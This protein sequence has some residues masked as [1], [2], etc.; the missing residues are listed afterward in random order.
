[1]LYYVVMT[2]ESMTDMAAC[3]HFKN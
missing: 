1:M 3:V 2:T